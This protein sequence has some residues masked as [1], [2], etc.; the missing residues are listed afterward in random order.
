MKG[1]VGNV[2]SRRVAWA[3]VKQRK[4]AHVNFSSKLFWRSRCH[5]HRRGP[6]LSF[7]M[8]G[9]LLPPPFPPPPHLPEDPDP[10]VTYISVGYCK[11]L[12]SRVY[13][14]DASNQSTDSDQKAI[15]SVLN[16]SLTRLNI[17][18]H[19]IS[20][21]R[22]MWRSTCLFRRRSTNVLSVWSRRIE[23]NV[24]N[25]PN[26]FRRTYMSQTRLVRLMK[27]SAFGQGLSVTSFSLCRFFPGIFLYCVV[28]ALINKGSGKTGKDMI[29]NAKFWSNL[30]GL[31]SVSVLVSEKL[32]SFL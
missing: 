29:P 22:R 21:V 18:F 5:C 30:P 7:L 9:E 26:S 31:I 15:F 32:P 8:S 17:H 14:L 27:S 6:C 16:F 4:Y 20:L 28:G 23:Q 2:G 19:T 12:Y 3:L 25:D 11:L 1:N 24:L 13:P 10:V